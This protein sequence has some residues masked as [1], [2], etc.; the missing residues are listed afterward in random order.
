MSNVFKINNLRCAYKETNHVVLEIDELTIPAGKVT[1]IIGQSGSGKSTFIET[2]GLMNH[3]ILQGNIEFTGT[4]GEW[5]LDSKAWNH[6]NKLASLR[7]KYFSFIFQ[8]DYLMPYYTP[9]E[10]IMV[11]QS[12][13]HNSQ[14]QAWVD[15]TSTIESD[16]DWVGLSLREGQMPYQMSGGQRQRLSFVRALSKDY[17]VIFGDEPTGNLDDETSRRLME[18]LCKSLKHKEGRAAILVSHNI[19]LSVKYSNRIIVLTP[20]DREGFT[21]RPENVFDKRDDL[22]INAAGK[23]MTDMALSA[24]ILDLIA[25]NSTNTKS[26]RIHYKPKSKE[27]K[28]LQKIIRQNEFKALKVTRYSTVL[29]LLFIL[30][31]SFLCFGFSKSA[32]NYQ[33]KLSRDPFSNWVNIVYNHSTEK[34]LK[35]L[36]RTAEE[37]S[38]LISKFHINHLFYYSRWRWFTRPNRPDPFPELIQCRSID[39]NA[40][41]IKSLL[42]KENIVRINVPDKVPIDS[43]FQFEPNGLI[44]TEIGRPHV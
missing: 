17:T 3:T 6:P 32:F 2:L 23:E 12:D 21:V 44:V 26:S 35:Q 42:K 33:E 16:C 9:F 27:K 29:Y 31:I 15:K 22:W 7:K 41:V 40:G 10:N 36:M 1:S 4:D 14:K 34:G 24:L 18:V 13:N 8:N 43:L 28:S 20:G 25:Q 19:M 37:D 30:W 38:S 39:Q 11:G 5:K